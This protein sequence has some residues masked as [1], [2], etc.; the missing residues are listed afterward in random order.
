MLIMHDAPDPTATGR[1][2]RR[3]EGKGCGHKFR[4]TLRVASSYDKLRRRSIKKLGLVALA[5]A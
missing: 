2:E 4:Q 1:R 5:A 3:R